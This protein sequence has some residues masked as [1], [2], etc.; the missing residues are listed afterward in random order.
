MSMEAATKGIRPAS[1][2]RSGMYR[3]WALSYT[4]PTVR[5]SR[6]VMVPW[7]NSCIAA[8]LSP[9]AVSAPL[10][11]PTEPMPSITRPMWLRLE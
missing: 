1:P 11:T 10:E 3:V 7:V 9:V 5:N 6:P 8:P 2:P 4:K